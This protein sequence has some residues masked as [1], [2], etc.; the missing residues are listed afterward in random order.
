MNR[1]V[2][3]LGLLFILGVLV[4]C[5]RDPVAPD[6]TLDTTG[7]M[8]DSSGVWVDAATGESFADMPPPF[9]AMNQYCFDCH[10]A[11]GQSD[12]ADSARSKLVMNTWQDVVAFGPERILLAARIGDMPPTTSAAV[13]DSILSQVEML[14][15]SWTWTSNQGNR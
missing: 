15:A 2:Y 12:A 1:W 4:Q 6:S 14:L 13:P 7:L 10:S 8:R 3:A 5:T 9:Q 11:R